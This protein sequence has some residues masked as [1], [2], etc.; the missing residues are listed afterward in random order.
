MYFMHHLG[1][2]NSKEKWKIGIDLLVKNHINNPDF[3][4]QVKRKIEVSKIEDY[5]EM[6]RVQFQYSLLDASLGVKEVSSKQ[7]K[8]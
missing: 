2:T 7:I 3:I 4:E 5:K 6:A 8:I 1:K